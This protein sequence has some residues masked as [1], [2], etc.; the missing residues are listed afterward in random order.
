MEKVIDEILKSTEQLYG[1]DESQKEITRYGLLAFGEIGSN[2]LISLLILYRMDVIAE[3]CVFFL[4]FIPVR[5]FSGGYYLGSYFKCLIFSVVT[6]I[7]VLQLG[8]IVQISGIASMVVIAFI[9]SVIWNIAPVLHPNRPVS[10][11][12]YNKIK[13]R[14]KISSILVFVLNVVLR[15]FRLEQMSNTVLLCMTL[16]LA[17]LLIGK[18][19]YKECQVRNIA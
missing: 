17:T 14:M 5:M 2:V 8:K 19:K 15:V 1:F 10:S 7:G 18:I 11:K 13:K 4:V 12:G 3:G 16:I 9:D 6:L